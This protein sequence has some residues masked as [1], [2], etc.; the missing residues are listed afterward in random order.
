LFALQSFYQSTPWDLLVPEEGCNR[1]TPPGG[2]EFEPLVE[3]VNLIPAGAL[4]S[5]GL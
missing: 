1:D 2:V 3:I 5:Q 4:E